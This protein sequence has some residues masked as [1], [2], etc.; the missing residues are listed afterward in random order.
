MQFHRLLLLFCLAGCNQAFQT[1]PSNT[2]TPSPMTWDEFYIQASSPE[3]GEDTYLSSPTVMIVE[4]DIA[5]HDTGILFEYYLDYL[6]RVS[7]EKLEN[8][9]S[10]GLAVKRHW[11]A[12]DVFPP[13]LQRDITY[14]LDSPAFNS[15][16]PSMYT[17]MRRAITHSARIWDNVVDVRFIHESQFD[18]SSS[19]PCTDNNS[20]VIFNVT[21]GNTAP[22]FNG[23]PAVASA[24]FPS[25]GRNERELIFYDPVFPSTAR[26]TFVHELAHTLG[27]KHEGERLE[28][29]HLNNSCY[30]SGHRALTIFDPSSVTGTG[31][32]PGVLDMGRPTELDY[33]G[34]KKLYGENPHLSSKVSMNLF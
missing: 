8:T 3:V 20:E 14:C 12:D 11:G 9:S 23:L 25:Y 27:F 32:C 5:V 24:F 30:D 34:A 33:L 18:S 15:R 29:Q 10:Q 1:T 7:P 2:D 4:G 22:V 16:S 6:D 21:A 28:V 17:R 31:G 19:N 13:S 26:R